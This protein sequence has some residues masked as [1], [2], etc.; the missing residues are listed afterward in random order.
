MADIA[1]CRAAIEA[2][3]TQLAFVHMGTEEQARALFSRY[4]LAD[5]PRISDPDRRLYEA[6]G[7]FL[8]SL[9]QHFGP[10]SL[11]RGLEAL[12][13]GNSAGALVG[14]GLQMPGLFLIVNGRI[15]TRFVHETASDRPDYTT[16]ARGEV[17]DFAAR[18]VESDAAPGEAVR[19]TR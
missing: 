7:L 2:A 16:L 6:F 17:S 15:T 13:R 18:P 14:H 19:N 1:Q 9:S 8:G 12:A 10:R 4:G 3:G 11:W 5:L